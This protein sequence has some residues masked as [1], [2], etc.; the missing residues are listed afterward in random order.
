VRVYTHA[1]ASGHFDE[2]TIF[3]IA[4]NGSAAF[5]ANK[6]ATA[7]M[8][9]FTLRNPPHFM[10]FRTP[11][12]RD[13]MYETEAL[14]HHL[15]WHQNTA[16][17]VAHRLIQRM[18]TSNPSPRYTK[19]VADAFRTGTYDGTRYSQEYG[20]LAATVHA[21]LLDREARSLT[22]D[23]DPSHGQ[24][25]EPLLRVVHVM[26]AMEYA[27]YDGRDP[28]M[29]D[30]MQK[31]G[32]QV[33]QSPGVFNFFKPEYQALG[34]VVES[35]LASPEFEITYAPT[36]IGMMNGMTSL[37]R[38][39]LNTCDGGFGK[40]TR[41]QPRTGGSNG[42]NCDSPAR[43]IRYPAVDGQSLEEVQ[44]KGALDGSSSD[45]VLNISAFPPTMDAAAA[46]AELDLLLTAGRLSNVSRQVIEVEY[47]RARDEYTY[48]FS[49]QD[50][51]NCT[52]YPDGEIITTAE[53]CE[54]AAR[55]LPK[56][57]KTV[58]AGS[59]NWKPVGCFYDNSNPEKLKLNAHNNDNKNSCTGT[60]DCLCRARG[61]RRALKRAVELLLA[62]PDFAVTNLAQ[63]STTPRAA[64]S[65]PA[66][67]GRP[68]KALVVLFLDG[69]ADSWNMIV[70]H[71]GCTPGNVSA[72]Y[73][74]YHTLRGGSAEGVAL[75]KEELL[76]INV[77]NMPGQPAQP[78]S[79][80]GVHP[81]LSTV[82]R[83]YEEGDA[84]FFSNVG[85]LVEP[86]TKAEYLAK[87]KRRPPNLFAHNVQ[88]KVTQSM[89]PQDKVATGVLGRLVDVLNRDG[90]SGRAA[91]RTGTYSLDGMSKMV[92]GKSAPIVLDK[93][94]VVSFA[95]H[96]DMGEALSNITLGG[97]GGGAQSY[98]S[99]FGETFARQLQDALSTSQ[100]LDVATS[101]VSL[102]AT[103]PQTGNLG[104]ELEQVARV[105]AARGELE[106]ERQVF[107]VTHGGF[108]SH[109]SLKDQV[110]GH[111][112]EIN[113]ALEAFQAE[114]K[115]QG[116]WED[117]ILLTASDFARTYAMN[118]AGT[119]HAWGGNYFALGGAVNGSQLFGEFP[120]SF[121]ETSDV[122]I[123]RN[124]R[125]IPTTP[126]ESVWFGLAEWFGADQASMAE[127]LPNYAN[128]NFSSMFRASAA[129]GRPGLTV[130]SRRRR[131]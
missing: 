18:V 118:G 41:L 84:A 115:A 74:T 59:W 76:T 128:F 9:G 64:A 57:D 90:S 130:A 106:E 83:L 46:V 10:S 17:F 49:D 93:R 43:L 8:A 87:Q 14:L 82:R 60:N 21:M 103:F 131:S 94:G 89:H 1:N 108:D 71:S 37:V 80:L 31:I 72:N 54:A 3:E 32:Q 62:T 16:P 92:E 52:D 97:G 120:S 116:V 100:T 20:S 81:R 56:A 15:M 38:Y 86:M 28:E 25:R 127:V 61:E 13:L 47:L 39:G 122:V 58:E 124:G 104:R 12:K 69:G 51:T 109:A 50:G 48:F 19:V 77:P 114:L 68:Y 107:L 22:L 40:Y 121:T 113:A 34:S 101:G 30:M 2:R 44:L 79:M 5:F 42:R 95:H 66:S 23:L 75:R 36:I 70:P 7:S 45:G 117:T 33:F 102:A 119:D 11:T 91:F 73:E 110:D 65:R 85:T 67:G 99:V 111:F 78:C 53:G 123:S 125:L 26:R 4:V 88:V 55:A 112:L 96:A 63:P 98:K 105:I 24:L 6:E 35:N 27:S 29:N 126:W 129:D